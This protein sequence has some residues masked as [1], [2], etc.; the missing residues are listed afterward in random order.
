MAQPNLISKKIDGYEN[1]LLYENGVVI[2]TN[3]NKKLTI[4][5]IKPGDLAK[6]PDAKGVQYMLRLWKNN[7]STWYNF[8]RLM[9]KS[10]YNVTL[11]PNEI[12]IIKDKDI[13]EKF[14]YTNLEKIV[15]TDLEM[16]EDDLELDETK[17]WKI[18]KNYPKYKISNYGDIYS[19]R[20]KKMMT[21]GKGGG[22]YYRLTLTNEAGP[23]KFLVHRLL[24]DAFEGLTDDNK[25]IDH[26]DWNKTNNSISNLRETS[27]SEN[28]KNCDTK[29]YTKSPI[30]QYSLDNEF[31]KEWDSYDDIYNELK[32]S[33][34]NISDCCLGKTKTAYKFIWK[35]PKV[36]TDLT[37]YKT[38]DTR[39]D[40]KFSN[41]KINKIGTIIGRNN[42]IMQ[43]CK[44]KGDDEYYRIGLISDAG[45][46]CMLFVHKLVG[47]THIY[48]PDP[49]IYTIVNHKD[50]NKLNNE[51]GNLEWV[52]PSENTTYSIGRKTNKV[53]PKTNEILETYD[54]ITAAAQSLGKPHGNLSKVL[55][56]KITTA[57]GFKWTYAD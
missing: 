32:Y 52:T 35:N 16:D 15:R 43:P 17:I 2:N 37:D 54:S 40:N 23:K 45:K 47:Q 41:Y 18:I 14:C 6:T 27:K 49:K 1:Y 4:S 38:V 13:D 22:E 33:S 46:T 21:L 42:M 56:G 19:I 26:K 30:H 29:I 8:P 24:Y 11:E 12:I 55:A 25:V 50:E 48:N 5:V 20:Q 57:Y 36:V 7:Y 31:I 39:N 10:F 9:F 34:G 28:A 53:D 44:G 51:M 3:T